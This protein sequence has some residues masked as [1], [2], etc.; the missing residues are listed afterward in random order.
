MD[1]VLFVTTRDR[2]PALRAEH[3]RGRTRLSQRDQAVRPFADD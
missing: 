2:A 1:N 3:S